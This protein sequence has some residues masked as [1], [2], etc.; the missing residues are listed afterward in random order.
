[1]KFAEVFSGEKLHGCLEAFSDIRKFFEMPEFIELCIALSRAYG[2]I[3]EQWKQD[4]TTKSTSIGFKPDFLW[5][6][7]IEAIGLS[8]S[9]PEDLIRIIDY[10]I[11]N[12]S[13][14]GK[15]KIFSLFHVMTELDSSTVL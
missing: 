8:V 10:A 9:G 5:L 7:F 12:F 15:S 11:T 3:D 1:M 14:V 4:S 13:C 6:D 2:M